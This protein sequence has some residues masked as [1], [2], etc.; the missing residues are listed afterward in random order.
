MDCINSWR[1]LTKMAT[2]FD[3]LKKEYGAQTAGPQ[4]QT[5]GKFSL[6]DRVTET[7]TRT[8]TAKPRVSAAPKTENSE[9]AQLYANIAR[10][11]I[12]LG[13]L[14]ER[15][16]KL[17]VRFKDVLGKDKWITATDLAKIAFYNV[18]LRSRKAT[19]VK[20]QASAR[21]GETIDVLTQRIAEVI[22][23]QHENSVKGIEI[24]KGVRAEV[25]AHT[26]LTYENLVKR[27]KSGYLKT[28]DVVEGEK[29]VDALEKELKD[30]EAVIADYEPKIIEAQKN[31]DLEGIKR[32]TGELSEIVQEHAGL[33]D[34]KQDADAIVAE[35]KRRI[36]DYSEGVQSARNAIE[37][38]KVS[39]LQANSLIDSWNKLEI[40][41]RHAK[42]DMVPI[43]LIQG[44]IAAYGTR[45]LQMNDLLK[46]TAATYR[47]LLQHNEKL[48]V[49]FAEETFKLIELDLY[50]PKQAAEI[51][52][53]LSQRLKQQS[54]LEMKF[55]ENKR[56]MTQQL[57][58]AQDFMRDTPL[59]A[60]P[61]YT[62]QK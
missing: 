52:E 26:K 46:D 30:Y 51:R 32:L 54:E 20:V 47:E 53:R 25:T 16:G 3:R 48:V 35:I 40:K 31:K 1:L 45:G 36:L 58:E 4:T 6:D 43:Y 9:T 17:D 38:L 29:Q 18:T 15:Y 7:G 10:I 27:L 2:D 61:G 19:E 62:Q 28:V 12:N 13:E 33:I 24:A 5:K 56:L 49:A 22:S 57:R 11:Q 39:E 50:D 55:A 41:Y 34:Q 21:K 8:E 59:P 14:A 23:E 44:R 37:A 60:G 42:E